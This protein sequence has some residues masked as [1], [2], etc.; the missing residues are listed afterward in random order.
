[1][2]NFAVY[3]VLTGS[4]EKLN[5]QLPKKFPNTRFI[6]F[7]D[8]KELRS[9]NWFIK[10]IESKENLSPHRLSRR[11]KMQPWRYISDIDELLYIDNT[12]TLTKEPLLFYDEL[13][14]DTDMGFISHSFHMT[15]Y[16]EMYS[17]IDNNLV[18]HNEIIHWASL[19]PTFESNYFDMKPIWGG[20]IAR[21]KSNLSLEFGKEW[22]FEYLRSPARDQLTL[23]VVASRFRKDINISNFDNQKSSYHFWP[24]RLRESR[25]PRTLLEGKSD[26]LSKLKILNSFLSTSAIQANSH[27]M[28]LRAQVS[29]GKNGYIIGRI[30]WPIVR[31]FNVHNFR[32]RKF[33]KFGQLIFVLLR[34]NPRRF[35]FRIIR[36]P[37]KVFK[38][39]TRIL[40]SGI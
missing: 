11:L 7:T 17:I 21:R 33:R 4:Y 24:N 39:A 6:C 22:W 2:R 5:D 31:V 10:V 38:S 40:K 12:V 15:M 14:K 25:K 1:M 28:M 27:K 18:N 36:H 16:E 20:I 19:A 37:L 34:S 23:A 32:I 9:E 35:I 13:I 30:M 26:S 29:S 8:N 3:S